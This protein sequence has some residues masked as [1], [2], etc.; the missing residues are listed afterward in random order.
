MKGLKSQIIL[1]IILVSVLPLGIFT[2]LI[3]YQNYN[4][5]YNNIFSH[6]E[7]STKNR[8][9]ILRTYFKPIF[10]MANMLSND[11]NV[12][13]AFENKYDERVWMLKNF[14]NIIKNYGGYDAVYLGLKDKTMLMKPDMELPEDYDPTVRPWYKAAMNKPGS[15]VVSEPYA[16]A[17]SG[18]ILITVS[19]TVKNE[20]GEIIGVLGIDLSIKKIVETFLSEQMYEE[21]DPY[22]VDEKGI[23]LVHE[24][25]DKWGLDVSSMEFFTKATSNEGVVEYTYNN[26]TKL[27]FYYKTCILL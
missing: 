4:R 22:I 14:D 10:D 12:K 6:L 18:E 26:V 17:S 24:D 23:T 13:G 1:I 15:V 16:D 25:P 2:G 7:V 20:K 3:T 27:A 9:E 8:A 19:K 5:T 21:E 11:A